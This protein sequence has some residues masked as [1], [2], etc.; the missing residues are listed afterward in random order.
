M[1]QFPA[2]EGIK[3]IW[4]AEI[5]IHVTRQGIGLIS[6][7]GINLIEGHNFHIGP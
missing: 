4:I 2:S 6:F 5:F 1:D 3:L 7:Q